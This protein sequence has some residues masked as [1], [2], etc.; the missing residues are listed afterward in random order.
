MTQGTSSAGGIAVPLKGQSTITQYLIDIAIDI[1]TIKGASGQSGKFLNLVN[2]SDTS[3]FSI[4]ASGNV[5]AAGNIT[6][7][8]Y[9]VVKNYGT[10][11]PG[12]DDLAVD[13]AFAIGATNKLCWR[14]GSTIFS[15]AGT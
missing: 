2:S 10:D 11:T 14:S 5:V 1:L 9:L 7:A 15:V 8:G 13:G 3:K 6:T 12:T 4:D